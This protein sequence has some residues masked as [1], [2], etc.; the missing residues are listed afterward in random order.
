MQ[1]K[2]F[3][4]VILT[5]LLAFSCAKRDESPEVRSSN[6]VK[7]DLGI[8]V[9]F[10][11]VPKKIIS[12]APNLTEM[13]YSLGMGSRLVG[14]TL[15][16]TYP[17]E[18]RKVT[19]VGD[20]LTIDYEKILSLKPDLVLITVEGNAKDSYIKL[21]NLGLKVF[22]SNPRN[23]DGIKKTYAD[24]GK[25]F[26]KAR[27]ADSTISLWQAQ[28]DSV[29]TAAGR[30]EHPKCLF[31]VGFN[32]IMVAGKNT[33]INGLLTSAGLVNIAGDSQQ[34]YP[35]YSREEILKRNPD[36][37]L[38]TGTSH[39]GGDVIRNNYTEWKSLKAVKNNN[40]IV[41]DPDLY[42]RPGPRFTKALK[43]LFLKIHPQEGRK[44]LRP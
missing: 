27:Q 18:A 40:I 20:M 7:D 8:V 25:I 35:V 30:I 2:L 22:V 34:N 31:F 26:G 44:Y 13:V 28:Y 32:P 39:T 38:T 11:D 36:F 9:P 19:K 1:I 21:K 14:N 15:Y 16:C 41:L 3:H 24:L 23:F 10:N 17:P 42:L 12:M 5:S 33:F 43:E 37:L 29:T 6:P 4:I